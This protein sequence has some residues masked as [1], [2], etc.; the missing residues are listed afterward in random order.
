MD[1]R[2]FRLFAG[3]LAVV[4][5]VVAA[6]AF[7][8]GGTAPDPEAP[9]GDALV[10]VVVDVESTGLDSV[11]AF[12]LRTDDGSLVE[13]RIGVIENGAEFPPGHLAEHQVTAEPVRAWYR[14]VDGVRVAFRLEDAE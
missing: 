7:L 10:G 12:T 5:L 13:L 14:E 6:A 11:T 2:T 9:D 3:T 8:G 1:R 4:V